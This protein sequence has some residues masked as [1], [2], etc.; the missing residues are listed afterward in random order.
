MITAIVTKPK[1]KGKDS[2]ISRKTHNHK[3]YQPDRARMLSVLLA[4]AHTSVE[5]GKELSHG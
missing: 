2:S 1:M 5:A 4:I 3:Y